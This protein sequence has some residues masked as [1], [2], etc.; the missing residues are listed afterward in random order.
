MDSVFKSV[1]EEE[2]ERNLKKQVI[3]RNE[4]LKY[5]KG[6]LVI[7]I[8][9]GNK[10]LYRKYRS[11]NKII[12]EYIGLVDSDAAKEAYKNRNKYL[13]LKQDLK[14]LKDEEIR[15]RKAIKIYNQIK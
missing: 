4:F 6:S 15:L 1:L 9:H 11:N 14:E 3:F 13:Q 2:L 7:S 5:K 10:Y 8:I 12:S